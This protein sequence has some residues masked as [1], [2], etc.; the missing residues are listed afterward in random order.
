MPTYGNMLRSARKLTLSA[1]IAVTFIGNGLS[2][3]LLVSQHADVDVAH[4][5]TI[6]GANH[7]HG[8]H[9]PVSEAS[10][11]V[12]VQPNGNECGDHGCEPDEPCGKAHVHCCVSVVALAQ[13]ASRELALNESCS[14]LA[15]ADASRLFGNIGDLLL[16]PPRVAA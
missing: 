3:A 14:K 6:G 9:H 5:L 13:T 4:I 1:L 11:E 2:F 15:P 16:R 7:D 10:F 12:A 8:H